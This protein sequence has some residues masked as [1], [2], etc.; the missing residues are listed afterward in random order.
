MTD[1]VPNTADLIRLVEKQLE[2]N[3]ALRQVN[4]QLLQEL[5]KA[6][7]QPVAT[8][9]QSA[10]PTPEPAK[11]WNKVIER[12]PNYPRTSYESKKALADE[13]SLY[14]KEQHRKDIAGKY[15]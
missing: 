7:P 11:A 14:I 15:G 6:P 2:D 5:G 8:A 4:A 9:P 10:A 12:L 1:N 13:W 3:I